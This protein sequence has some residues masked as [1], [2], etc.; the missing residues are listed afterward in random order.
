MAND[1]AIKAEAAG[2]DKEVP[3]FIS[4][5][6][7]LLSVKECAALLSCSVPSIWR[8]VAAEQFPKPIKIGHLTRWPETEVLAFVSAAKETRNAS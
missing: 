8:W 5:D 4:G 3:S 6:G 7:K 1:C 2:C